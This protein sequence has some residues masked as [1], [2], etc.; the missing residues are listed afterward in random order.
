MSD[1]WPKVAKNQ[2]VCMVREQYKNVMG[3]LHI[4][5]LVQDWPLVIVQ[6]VRRNNPTYFLFFDSGAFNCD[7]K[8]FHRDNSELFVHDDVLRLNNLRIPNSSS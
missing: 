2:I 4:A 5:I 3:V 6:V 8:E 7:L 1:V